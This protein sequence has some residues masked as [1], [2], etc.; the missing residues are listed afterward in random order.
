MT[1]K[2]RAIKLRFTTGLNHIYGLL[3]LQF[4]G[5]TA[6]IFA[7]NFTAVGCVTFATV[8]GL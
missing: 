2:F 4:H 8:V 5:N 6:N 1:K 7:V 3:I